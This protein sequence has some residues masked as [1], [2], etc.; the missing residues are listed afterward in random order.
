MPQLSY[1]EAL[2]TSAKHPVLV[3]QPERFWVLAPAGILFI[4]MGLAFAGLMIV[5]LPGPNTEGIASTILMGLGLGGVFVIAGAAL[6]WLPRR[7]KQTARLT[8]LEFDNQRGFVTLVEQ[9]Q[10]QTH[11]S[12][13]PYEQLEGFTMFPLT[14]RGH[15]GAQR[16]TRH[17]VALLTIHGACWRLYHGE[18]KARARALLERLLDEVALENDSEPLPTPVSSARFE[19]TEG[20]EGTHIHWDRAQLPLVPMLTAIVALTVLLWLTVITP[21]PWSWLLMMLAAGVIAA[22][23]LLGLGVIPPP[24]RSQRLEITSDHLTS[25][26]KGLWRTVSRTISTTEV[27]AIVFNLGEGVSQGMY[28]LRE[29]ERKALEPYWRGEKQ[30]LSFQQARLLFRSM[31]VALDDL[32]LAEKLTLQRLLETAV[33]RHGSMVSH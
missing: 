4:G 25:T 32:T 17:V 22:G 33:M 3:S 1:D 15:D 28:L 24:T 14:T 21:P 29:A 31:T 9:R 16:W 2:S 30:K 6:F 12:H 19:V 11:T 26:Q 23:S 13:L 20:K 7:M 18:R 8:K 5:Y 10:G 27:D